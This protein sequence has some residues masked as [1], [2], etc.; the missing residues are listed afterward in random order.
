M[1]TTYPISAGSP[2]PALLRRV[3]LSPPGR[4]KSGQGPGRG[5]SRRDRDTRREPGLFEPYPNVLSE[6]V[7]AAEQMRDSADIEPKRVAA[8]DLD[9]GRPTA[10]PFGESLEQGPLAVGIGGNGNQAR[11]ECSRVG[12]P[13]ARPR[14]ALRGR[15]RDSMDQLPVRALDG[16]DDRRITR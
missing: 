13:S 4:G 2:Y 6:P 12:Q 9:Q 3:A 10:G 8:I 15:L 11:I 7:L 16:E 1:G 5:S 14:A